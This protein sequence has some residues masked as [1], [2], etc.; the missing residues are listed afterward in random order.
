MIPI[1][2]STY[3]RFPIMQIC[4]KSLME[5]DLPENVPIYAVDDASTDPRVLEF[6]NDFSIEVISFEDHF[7]LPNIRIDL[8]LKERSKLPN[9]ILRGLRIVYDRTQTE[10]LIY[11]QD[12][13]YC[14]SGW[15]LKLL[16]IK[17]LAEKAGIRV[18]LGTVFRCSNHHVK[19]TREKFD[20]LR[21][22][23][24]PVLL[25]RTS[26]LDEA[27]W[28]GIPA[29]S[30]QGFDWDIGKLATN[31]RWRK[32]ASEIIGSKKSWVEH[33]GFLRGDGT[34]VQKSIRGL[35]TMLPGIRD[36]YRDQ[37]IPRI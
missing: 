11:I 30:R 33:L 9:A 14:H 37:F 8:S 6:L 22:T 25:I 13:V 23:G 2:L 20:I 15:Y 36:K 12:D 24:A 4:V 28:E 18:G 17:Q 29:K 10:F 35:E 34:V 3:N 16:E 31:K 19:T 27:L 7:G 32:E 26:L 21:S 1:V 5:S